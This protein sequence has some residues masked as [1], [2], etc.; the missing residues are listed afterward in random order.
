MP[1][2]PDGSN[3]PTT[4]STHPPDSARRDAPGRPGIP[5][6]AS[7]PFGEHAR[8]R[9]AKAPTGQN[10]CRRRTPGP[11][12]EAP[13]DASPMEC[14]GSTS[15]K[16]HHPVI[17]PKGGRRNGSILRP[18]TNGCTAEWTFSFLS[19]ECS[20][21][22]LSQLGQVLYPSVLRKGNLGP[23]GRNGSER[24]YLSTANGSC[25]GSICSAAWVRPL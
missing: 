6:W 10:R 23:S 8:S 13:A 3:R 17:Q 21:S 20:S 2:T 22:L 9:W 14:L 7:W 18:N 11:A 16:P 12:K 5:R 19:T 1:P 24:R 15:Q 25:Q 4:S